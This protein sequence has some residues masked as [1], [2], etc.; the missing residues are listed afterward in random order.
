MHCIVF[1]ILSLKHE[2]RLEFV[3]VYQGA[4]LQVVIWY[5]RN[6][7]VATVMVNFGPLAAEIVSLVW[8]TPDNFNGFRVLAA[9]LQRRRSMKVNQI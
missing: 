8:G 5:S 7:L 9:L 4:S 6:F 2:P 1:T 3:L